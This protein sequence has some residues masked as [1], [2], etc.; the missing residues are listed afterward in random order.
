[1]ASVEAGTQY[2]WLDGRWELMIPFQP[3]GGRVLR[4]SY[5]ERAIPDVPSGSWRMMGLSAGPLTIRAAQ[6]SLPQKDFYPPG[7]VT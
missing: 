3:F 6:L 4:F 7:E 2:F 5:L 1:M